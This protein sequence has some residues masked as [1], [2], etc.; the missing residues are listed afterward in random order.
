MPPSAYRSEAG[1]AAPRNC[2]GAMNP[3]LHS[4][5]RSASCCWGCWLEPAAARANPER[6]R[7]H[8]GGAKARAVGCCSSCLDTP[9]VDQLDSGTLCAF[10][11]Q[12]IVGVEIPARHL[13]AAGAA[14][15][16]ASLGSWHSARLWITGGS[17]LARYCNTPSSSVAIL[18]TSSWLLRCPSLT[19][20]ANVR[21][22]ASSCLQVKSHSLEKG[23]RR[24]PPRQAPIPGQGRRCDP[25]GCPAQ[26]SLYTVGCRGGSAP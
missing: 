5:S 2:S 15:A 12:D 26:S 10:L 7:A 24:W 25:R 1:V 23:N 16:P 19:S 6:A 9:K 4:G 18:T 3:Q 21:P 20:C 17:L 14:A 8:N 13:E 11:H 22:A